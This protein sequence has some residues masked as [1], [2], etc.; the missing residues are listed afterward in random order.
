MEV[1]NPICTSTYWYN[2]FKK[3]F[4]A[5]GISDWETKYF[6]TGACQIGVHNSEWVVEG[7]LTCVAQGS[8]KDTCH[9]ITNHCAKAAQSKYGY[10][11]DQARAVVAAIRNG[12]RYPSCPVICGTTWLVIKHFEIAKNFLTRKK[13]TCVVQEGAKDT[14][15]GV[16]KFCANAAYTEGRNRNQSPRTKFPWGVGGKILLQDQVRITKAEIKTQHKT[17]V[18]KSTYGS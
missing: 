13:L 2:I 1:R 7:K 5:E 10:G 15:N 9:S 8:W 3:V 6:T 17:A 14:C 16:T 11:G 4:E 12:G 18:L